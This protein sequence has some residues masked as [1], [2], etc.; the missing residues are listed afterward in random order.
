MIDSEILKQTND[1]GYNGYDYNYLYRF[2]GRNLCL[3]IA[4]NYFFILMF[5]RE[6]YHIVSV[7]PLCWILLLQSYE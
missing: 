4:V 3:Y 2:V 6:V 5:W 1:T 7:V